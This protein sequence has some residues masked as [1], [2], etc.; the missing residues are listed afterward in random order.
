MSDTTKKLEDALRNLCGAI[1]QIPEGLEGYL[2]A[3]DKPLE[4]AQ[5]LLNT[6]DQQCASTAKDDPCPGC[7]PGGW[8]RTPNCGRLK[9]QVPAPAGKEGGE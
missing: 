5:Q 3:L 4:E 2:L 6:L 1:E 9:L 7:C 8:C